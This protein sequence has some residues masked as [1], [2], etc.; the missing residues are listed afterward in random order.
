MGHWLRRHT[1]ALKPAVLAGTE[2]GHPGVCPRP[3]P[4]LGTGIYQQRRLW[5]VRAIQKPKFNSL[6]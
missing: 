5:D 6:T 2:Q 1:K 4:Q 3:C